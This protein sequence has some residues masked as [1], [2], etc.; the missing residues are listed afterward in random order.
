MTCT[1]PSSQCKMARANVASIH[2]RQL[3]LQPFVELLHAEKHSTRWLSHALDVNYSH[4]VNV[5]SGR[6]PP[7]PELRKRL[8]DYFKLPEDKLFT[9]EALVAKYFPR[10][11]PYG[12]VK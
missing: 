12:D 6:V 1:Q 3:G 7:P 10:T 5:A 11:S 8:V 4:L 9:K 2:G